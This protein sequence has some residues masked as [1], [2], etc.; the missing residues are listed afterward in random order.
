MGPATRCLVI[1][2][3]TLLAACKTTQGQAPQPPVG[4]PATPGV[5]ITM[6]ALHQAG[7]VPPGWR[8]TAPPGDVDSGRQAF[9][10]LG[11][12]SCHHVE[13][14]HFSPGDNRGG[15][16][17]DLTGMG[18]HHPTEYFVESILNPDAVLVEGPGYIDQDG[19][20]IMPSYPE[21]TL[22]QLADLVA[23]LKSLRT[24]GSAE[25]KVTPA[26]KV[27]EAVPAPPDGAA[28]IFYVQAYD[29]LPGKLTTLEEW[30]RN[31]GAT[32]FLAQQGLVS[33]ETYVD[34]ARECP[35]L[36][37]VL[38]FRDEAA[39][40]QF[41]DDPIAQLLGQKLDEFGGPHQHRI[42]RQPPVYRAAA[43]SAP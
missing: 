8:F 29:V 31:E 14:E 39:L 17:P 24:S 26:E 19:R 11:C 4:H 3:A 16:G 35:S 28:S 18:S 25:M 13:G 42:F 7:G 12:H 41:L 38:G 43:L 6:A 2:L 30:F 1:G 21:L 40:T 34:I 37:T 20:S 33:I 23:Y 15:V 32:A 5:R 27:I 36:V 10:D 9:V 22:R